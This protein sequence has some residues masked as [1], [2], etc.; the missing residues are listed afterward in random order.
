MRKKKKADVVI[1]FVDLDE[2]SASSRRFRANLYPLTYSLLLT[3][4]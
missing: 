4:T 1:A 3:N 2:C